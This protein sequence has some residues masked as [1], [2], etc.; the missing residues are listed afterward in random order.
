MVLN[1]MYL[2]MGFKS[3]YVTCMPSDP[4]DNDCHVINIVYSETLN[5][6]LWVDPSFGIY[7]TDEN[8]NMLGIAETRERL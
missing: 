5:K 6:W 7:V 2:A 1:E 4:N 8:N 3:R